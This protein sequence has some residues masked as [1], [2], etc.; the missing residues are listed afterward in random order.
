MSLSKKAFPL[1]YVRSDADKWVD[2]M[3][4]SHWNVK[5]ATYGAT[6]LDTGN[7]GTAIQAAINAAQVTGGIVYM[8]PGRYRITTPLTIARGV[9]LRGAG[10]AGG[11]RGTY[12]HIVNNAA[13]LASPA[14]TVNGYGVTLRDFAIE[15]DQPPAAG[16]WAPTAYPYTIKC[17]GFP[18]LANDILI[19]NVFFYNSTKGIQLG[20]A[21]ASIA[22][23]RI[24]LTNISG[25]VFTSGMQ[26]DYA[27]DSIRIA[28]VHFWP[29]WSSHAAVKAW[30]LANLNGFLFYR[31]D[32]MVCHDMFS[33]WAHTGLYLGSNAFGSTQR[34]QM[35]NL[36]TDAIGGFGILV[37]GNNSTAQLSNYSVTVE[38]GQADTNALVVNGTDV[39]LQLNNFYVA[40][41]G[42][43]AIY[44]GAASRVDIG[45]FRTEV[46]SQ[47]GGVWP[48]IEVANANAVVSL[49]EGA[50]F[51]RTFGVQVTPAAAPDVS[52]AGLVI[53]P[54]Y[55]GHV[56]LRASA[57]Q[58][59]PH[60]TNY[61]IQYDVEVLD[62]DGLHTAGANTRVTVK[63]TGWYDVAAAVGFVYNAT[64]G[65]RT[66]Q[67]RKGGTT[68][69]GGAAQLASYTSS[70]ST[71][72]FMTHKTKIYLLAGEYFEVIVF[73]DL[74]VSLTITFDSGRSPE[75]IVNYLGA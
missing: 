53:Q 52:G 61:A 5:E 4:Q 42:R 73:Q 10:W 48:A 22:V 12:L 59:A 11:S 13:M 29:F 14:I 19:D 8:P 17:S 23:G 31:T 70:L 50:T 58:S 51:T 3:N 6:G 1:E 41:L 71:P 33:L 25:Q 40:G 63:R 69:V 49:D 39:Q 66:V 18:E 68:F 37:D 28:H 65:Q 15:H 64:A 21:A 16:G 60:N 2:F 7:D 47:D 43:R 57:T 24:H 32:G 30:T 27:L 35:T 38:P 46:W 74:G 56:H 75:L 20:D 45:N 9:T 26:V 67:L 54:G 72:A 44:V 36:N 62:L 55:R 34:L